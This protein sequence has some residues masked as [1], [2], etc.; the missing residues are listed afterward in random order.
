MKNAT[1][2]T[3]NDPSNISKEGG[4]QAAKLYNGVNHEH[5]DVYK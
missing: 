1:K 5:W 2:T 3:R 4:K